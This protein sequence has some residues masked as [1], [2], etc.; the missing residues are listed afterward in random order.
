MLEQVVPI[1]VDHFDLLP[2]VSKAATEA[3]DQ[4]FPYLIS[5][6]T[7]YQTYSMTSSLVRQPRML[8]IKFRA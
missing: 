4:Y 5:E 7:S 8:P 1:G 3:I 6:K 2:V